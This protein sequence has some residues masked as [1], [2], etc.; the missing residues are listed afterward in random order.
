VTGDTVNT[1]A[2]LE[3]HAPPGEVFLGEP[4]YR[5]VRDAVEVEPVESITAKGKAQ[6]VAAFRLVSV[7]P[8]VAGHARH[9]DRRLVGR[10]REL[11]ALGAEFE[12]A[13]AERSARLVTVLGTAGVGKSRLVAELVASLET[14][15]RVV[16]GRCLPYGE[17]ITYWP[18]RELVHGAAGITEADTADAAR[19]RI[20]GLLDGEPEAE[21]LARRVG[22]A[23]GLETE[24]AP[25]EEM[26]WAIR[27]LLEHLARDTPV[28][29]VIEDIHWA[30]PTLLDLLEYVVDL[31]ADAPLLIVCPAR[32]EL[33][34][35][36]PG[37]AGRSAT[38]LFRL[39]PLGADATEQLIDETP[40]G[41]ALPPG[42]RSRILAAAEGNPLFVEELL[43][44]L[45]DDGALVEVDGSWVA[46][47]D[48]ETLAIPLSIR[49]L[50]AARIDGLPDAERRVAERASVVGR[51]FEAAAVRELAG[52][53][54]TDVGRNLVAL[55][56]KE[57]VRPDRSEL[58]VGD[59][60]K[61]RHILIRDAAYEA[62]PKAE[63]AVLHERFA[64]WLV[65]VTG[66]RAAEYEEITGHHYAE[67]H[68]Y[69]I[70][71]GESGE[72]VDR[73][74]AQAAERLL[75][76]GK[77]AMDR[78]EPRAAADLL[79][80][81]WR[82]RT[83]AG[84]VN[85]VLVNEYA[86]AA[87]DAGLFGRGLE[88]IEEARTAISNEDD[89][90]TVVELDLLELLL[91]ES[92]GG[93]EWLDRV[94]EL[95]ARA[96]VD[97]LRHP[98]VRALWWRLQGEV[99]SYSGDISGEALAAR[100]MTAALKEAGRHRAAADAV[101]LLLFLLVVDQTPVPVAIQQCTGII[102]E[103]T[104]SQVLRS[105]GLRIRGYLRGQ[106]GQV[107]D[108]R[109]D[110]GEARRIA[111]T[112]GRP[113][114]ESNV[115]FFAGLLELDAGNDAAAEERLRDGFAINEAVGH[116]GF[117]AELGGWLGFALARQGRFD[118]AAPYAERTLRDTPP[119][120]L[121]YQSL[122]HVVT[123]MCAAP[124]DPK[125]AL[126]E[127]RE[128][129]R[130]VDQT[131]STL[132]RVVSHLAA[133]RVFLEVDAVSDARS[134]GEVALEIARVKGATLYVA[135]AERLLSELAEWESGRARP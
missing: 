4:T 99:A 64:D 2:R 22:A 54:A 86:H 111:R 9:L 127:A 1:A 126:A 135:T 11:D 56:R 45:V 108:G 61:F 20:R 96:P 46:A 55:V 76:A 92:A 78:A 10:N 132:V 129:L 51:T 21:L 98:R 30:E 79:D 115:A 114:G 88:V 71:L 36:R 47:A 66:E 134:S 39:E 91:T 94:R 74:A 133:A 43:A 14:R 53:G 16:R 105:V 3:Q 121:Y 37:W 102:E 100:S 24:P 17:G 58:V 40:G 49:A 68:R 73:L 81:A 70:E 26:F 87:L 75:A 29:V 104:S 124:R 41:E 89:D 77:R 8:D 18:I 123:A 38:N 13:V 65:R 50:L 57:L 25:Q 112:L 27:K 62:L 113:G 67:A 72:R 110:L 128:A 84:P 23:I 31:A 28:L 90:E 131:D 34:E 85:A 106:V 82:L 15:A 117:A 93:Q 59:A 101:G 7:R 119:E 60:F 5:L 63:R 33:L 19:A 6:P 48:L 122:A 103:Q 107:E 35:S 109:A 80:R 130:L 125:R 42:L 95:A 44:M 32:P 83:P 52:D 118:E 12:Q 120:D 97:G 69:R 116:R